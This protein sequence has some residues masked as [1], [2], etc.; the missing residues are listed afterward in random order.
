M[1]KKTANKTK[2][3]E[4]TILKQMFG[5]RAILWVL[6]FVISGV[7]TSLC[8]GIFDTWAIAIRNASKG[9]LRKFADTYFIRAAGTELTDGIS[10]ISI[11]LFILFWVGIWFFVKVL[12][13]EQ[14]R[15]EKE[16]DKIDRAEDFEKKTDVN[17]LAKELQNLRKKQLLEL[18]HTS[19]TGK[20]DI[21]W[22]KW[23][24]IVL[25]LFSLYSMSLQEVAYDLVKIYRRDITRVRPFI[26]E[27]E[28]HQL[29]RQ[30]V[31]MKSRSDYKAIKAVIAEYEK[32]A[33]AD[34]KPE[35]QVTESK[36][37]PQS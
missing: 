27:S 1:G 8:T 12:E 15:I 19:A 37:E 22:I 32:R 29:N 30:W 21:K 7:A 4:N 24:F 23:L 10:S 20:R 33:E 6:G 28:L 11:L 31:M 17:S 3:P 9:F 14:S 5:S 25:A 36:D 13:T 18:K 2:V 34:K 35:T 16:L 26:T